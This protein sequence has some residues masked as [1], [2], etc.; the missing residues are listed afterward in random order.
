[1]Q[2]PQLAN[3]A[4]SRPNRHRPTTS[5]WIAAS[6]NPPAHSLA[7]LSPGQVGQP[8]IDNTKYT[9]IISTLLI[10]APKTAST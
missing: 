6:S 2:S 9:N 4:G 5:L 10:Q 3:S 8:Q 7:G 1:M